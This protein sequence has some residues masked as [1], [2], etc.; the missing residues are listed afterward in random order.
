MKLQRQPEHSEKIWLALMI[1]NSRL[2]WALFL[3]DH[4]GCAW[5]TEYLTASV[6]QKLANS[7][8]LADLPTEL[9]PPSLLNIKS[10][11]SNFKA[12]LPLYLA[13]VVP[14]QTQIWQTYP[15]VHLITLDQVPLD[16]LYPT[17]GIDRALALWGARETWG[18]PILVVDAG[19]ALTFTGVNVQQQLV[20]GAILPGLSLQ[21]QSLAQR[22]AGLP[23]VHLENTMPL[24]QRWAENTLEAISS[25]VVYTLVAGIKDFIEAWWRD[26]P[27]SGVALTGGDRALLL[28]Y[29]QALFPEVGAKV[30]AD[31]YLTLWGIRAYWALTD[32]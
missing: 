27:N 9:L 24:P 8:S 3:E 1:G 12:T 15:D 17:L 5:D 19:T 4:L 6:V 29:L 26:F 21:M 28:N 31:P 20:G 18:L 14:R 2:H 25:G 22:T 30:I 16:H 11:I 23:L 7:R 10:Q 13:S 32:C